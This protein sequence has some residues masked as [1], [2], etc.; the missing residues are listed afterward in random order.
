MKNQIQSPEVVMLMIQDRF[1]HVGIQQPLLYCWPSYLNFL[2]L[3]FT[4]NRNNG[5]FERLLS[6]ERDDVCYLIT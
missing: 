5:Y 4:V 1:I 6:I 2:S 3:S